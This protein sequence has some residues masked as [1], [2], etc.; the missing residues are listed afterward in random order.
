MKDEDTLPI[1][2]KEGSASA[3]D[4]GLFGKGSYKFW[5]LAAILLLAF[6]SMFTGTVSLRW[7]GY[8]QHFLPRPPRAPPRPPRRPRKFP[9]LVLPFPR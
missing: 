9:L 2:K 1:A 6:W 4:L 8:A 5:A 3:S 7:S